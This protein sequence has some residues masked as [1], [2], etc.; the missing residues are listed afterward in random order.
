M[1]RDSEWNAG[2]SRGVHGNLRGHMGKV[3]MQMILY[4]SS[5]VVGLFVVSHIFMF[6]VEGIETNEAV[7]FDVALL[8]V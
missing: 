2:Q 5:V 8:R 6:Q 3:H 7:V 4:R 1:C